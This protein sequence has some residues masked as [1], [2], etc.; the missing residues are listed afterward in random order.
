MSSRHL[1]GVFDEGLDAG[2]FAYPYKDLYHHLD[3]LL[4]YREG[5]SDLRKRHPTAFNQYAD[6]H[7]DLL[8]SYLES[9]PTVQYKE[10]KARWSRDTPVTT[11]ATFWLLMKP[12]T[13]VYVREADGS[14]NRYVLDKLMGGI[15]QGLHGRNEA[16]NYTVQVWNLALNDRTIK[17]YSRQ[18]HVQ[19]FDDERKITELPVFPV[20]YHDEQDDGFVHQA[21]IDRGRKYSEYSKGPCFLQYNGVG[22]K[23]GSRSVSRNIY[24]TFIK[25]IVV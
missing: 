20:R 1:G 19:I 5:E 21:L 13:D 12:G 6:E 22:L 17:R 7:I 10:A 11:F 9:Q 4:R 23:P 16:R 24:I 8:Q 2:V 18:I 14:Y 3:D 25:L 15:S